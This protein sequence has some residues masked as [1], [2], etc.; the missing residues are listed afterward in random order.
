MFLIAHNHLIEP[1]FPHRKPNATFFPI[2]FPL[3]KSSPISFLPLWHIWMAALGQFPLDWGTSRHSFVQLGHD[4]FSH[5]W[6]SFRRSWPLFPLLLMMMM[7]F[8]SLLG[9]GCPLNPNGTL[10]RGWRRRW[11]NRWLPKGSKSLLCNSLAPLTCS[12]TIFHFKMPFLDRNL[13]NMLTAR[14]LLPPRAG[15]PRID[16]LS[17]FPTFV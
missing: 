17:G 4:F 6:N 11:G 8:I 14:L 10:R 12:L 1:F 15:S 7:V 2:S 5:F 3:Q 9:F 16:P 13:V